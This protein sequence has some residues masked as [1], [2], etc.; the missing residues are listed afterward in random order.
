MPLSSSDPLVSAYSNAVSRR[1]AANQTAAATSPTSTR[2][3]NS[4]TS[5]GVFGK[6]PGVDPSM[7]GA[8]RTTAAGTS[9]PVSGQPGAAPAGGSTGEWTMP[10]IT[11]PSWMAVSRGFQYQSD[12][13]DQGAQRRREQYQA[14][15]DYTRP[16]LQYQGELERRDISY[17]AEG[18][19]VLRSG[20]HE[21]A[22][23]EAMRKE[24]QRL[25]DLD[26]QLAENLTNVDLES[27]TQQ[28]DLRRQFAEKGQEAAYQQYV[29]EGIQKAQQAALNPYQGLAIDPQTNQPAQGGLYLDD[30]GNYYT[31]NAGKITNVGWDVVNSLGGTAAARQ[32]DANVS[33]HYRQQAGV[34]W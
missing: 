33:Q 1:A 31:I 27:S 24:Q 7:V 26:M 29:N 10:G 34:T 25:G 20:Q 30:Q 4:Q 11:D 16:Q 21:Q 12:T 13:L 5:A 18:R 19:G 17:D 23:A 15:A 3:F 14:R 8:T 32:L 22:L 2:D 28:A 6:Y 9:Q